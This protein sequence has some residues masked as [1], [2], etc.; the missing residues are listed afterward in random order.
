MQLKK[1]DAVSFEEVIYDNCEACLVVFSRKSCHVCQEIISII[2]DLLE[3]YEGKL[4]FYYIDV[5]QNKDLYKRFSLR[6]VPQILFFYGGEYKGKLVGQVEEED[7][8]AKIVEI[9]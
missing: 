1:L 2:E 6:G 7:V 8:E 5:E 3:K 4:G 9:L